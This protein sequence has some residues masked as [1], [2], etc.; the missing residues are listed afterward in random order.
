MKQSRFKSKVLW[1]AVA[2]QLISLGQLTG[3]WKEL[4]L[5]VGTIG[6]F[7]AGLLQLLVLIGVLNDPTTKDGF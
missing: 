1:A 7:V 2:L 3:L 5:D 4:G 6:D